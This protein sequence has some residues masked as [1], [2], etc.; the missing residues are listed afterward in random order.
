MKSETPPEIKTYSNGTKKVKTSTTVKGE[1][2]I[3]SDEMFIFQVGML[4]N[5]NIREWLNT[6]GYNLSDRQNN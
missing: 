3:Y 6:K 2:I 1:K 5:T 4:L